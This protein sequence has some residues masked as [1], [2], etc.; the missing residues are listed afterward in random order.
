MKER[1]VDLF[2]NLQGCLRARK[3]WL[4]VVIVALCLIPSTARAAGLGDIIS[5]LKTITST[6]HGAIGGSLNEI[7]NLQSLL[8]RFRQQ[9][10]WPLAAINQAKAFVNSTRG[11]YGHSMFGIV[12]IRNNSATL[13]PPSQLESLF[14]SGQS[15]SIGQVPPA[16]FSVYGAVPT[17]AN[18]QPQQ[19]NMMD[20]DDALAMG[21]LK[22]TVLSD[23]T[24][25]GALALADAIEQQSANTAPGSGPMLSTQAQVA[26]LET[27]ALMA[28]VLAAELR[29]EAAKLAHENAL[30]KQSSAA[31]RNLQN[32]MMQV[33]SHP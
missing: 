22:T 6:I 21:S 27:Q 7:Q 23:Q 4:P 9:T 29:A 14:R 19:R 33:L 5:L 28:K 25:Q 18:A 1:I 30:L 20:M 11:Q 13:I 8:N 3:Q 31:T 26:E 24:T 2:R 32:Q 16:Y 12:M 17:P 10:I 15:A